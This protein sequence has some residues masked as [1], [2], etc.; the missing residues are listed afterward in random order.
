[1]IVGGNRSWAGSFR[2]AG[3]FLAGGINTLIMIE[4][5]LREKKRYIVIETLEEQSYKEVKD[6]IYKESLAFLG[7][8]G[9]GE[10]R[11]E[12]TQGANA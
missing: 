8:K 3:R 9:T 6:N 7:E 5:A 11:T 4:P 10:R 2:E 1:M 12:G